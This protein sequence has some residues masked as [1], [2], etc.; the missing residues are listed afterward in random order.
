MDAKTNIYHEVEIL[1]V[2]DNMDDARLTIRALGKHNL[3]NKLI[4][5]GDGADAL[6]FLFCKGIYSER[7]M[8]F[9]PKVILL[10]L[11]MPKVNGLELLEKLKADERTQNIPVVILTSSNEDPDIEKAYAIGANSYI[12]K[13]VEFE[14]FTQTVVELGWYWMVV[15]RLPH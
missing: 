12:V 11:K 6:D 13:P 1:L 3:A 2:E 4:H 10:D 14:K 15:N 8:E 9:M 7:N 5:L